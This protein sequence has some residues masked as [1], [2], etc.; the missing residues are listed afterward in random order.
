MN[1]LSNSYSNETNNFP[2]VFYASCD[3]AW[4]AAKTLKRYS[5]DI[6]QILLVL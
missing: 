3:M 4:Y 6:D 1:Y 5:A 2:F